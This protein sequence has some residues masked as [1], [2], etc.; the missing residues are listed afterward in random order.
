MDVDAATRTMI[1]NIPAKTGRTLDEWFS[2]LDAAGLPQHGKA[3]AFLK[4]E[5]GV[6][7]GFA[8]L[9]VTLHRQRGTEAG[10][11]DLVDA[12]YAGAKAAL[13]PLYDR[14]VAAAG[15]LGSDVEIAPKKT[16]VSLRRARQFALIEAPSR[17]RIALGLNLRDVE[18]GGRL[19]AAGGMC[20]HRVDLGALEDIDAEVLGWLRE[21]YDRAG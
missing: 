11:A 7:H 18:A 12:Q 3:M 9:I 4:G 1:D 16:G 6:S 19:L 14:L 20:T 21:A 15:A 17:T 10:P 13:R 8:N 2:A 5:H